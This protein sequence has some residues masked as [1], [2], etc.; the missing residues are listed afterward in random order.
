MA[1]RQDSVRRAREFSP[2]LR[3]A[4]A[5]LPHIVA[6]FLEKGSAEAVEAALEASSDEVE[7]E[8]RRRR[9]GLAL[10]GDFGEIAG[11]LS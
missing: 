11:V 3:D 9:L 1:G 8:L 10:D 2:F 6:L 5:A 4:A 7:T